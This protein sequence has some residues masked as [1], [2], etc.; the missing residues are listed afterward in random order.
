[1]IQAILWAQWKSIRILRFGSG[2]RGA[3]FSALT[4]LLWYGFWA[5]TSV[6]LAS[7]VAD[8]KLQHDVEQLF[9]AILVFV[10]L[11]WQLAPIL[12]ASLGASL[13]LKKLLAYPIPI[14]SLFWVEVML[15]V[16]TGIEMLLVLAGAAIGLIRNPTFGGWAK[17]P[18]GTTE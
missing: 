7:F 15:R 8:P 3:V 10:I 11:Y 16:T 18:H 17:A 9:P 6:G 13:D 5:V 12:M 1:M 14:A 2:K 4:S